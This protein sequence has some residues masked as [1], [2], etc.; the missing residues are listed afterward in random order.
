MEDWD[1]YQN[2]NWDWPEV[3]PMLPAGKAD[4]IPVEILSEIF[5]FAVQDWIPGRSRKE[6][7]LVCR[8]WHAI[9][10]SIPGIPSQLTIRRATQK[11]VVQ[12]FIQG[13]RSRL[14]V[15]VD[16]NDETDGSDFNAENLHACLLAVAQ[17]A[18]RWSSLNLISPPP[19]GE[20]TNLHILQP[21]VHLKSFKLA[22]GFGE[23]VEPLMA[24]ISKS[25]TP[26]LTTMALKDPVAVFYLV[27]PAYLHITH[28]LTALTVLLAKRMDNPADILP[29]LH[30]LEFFEARNLGLP[31]YPPDVSLPLTHTLQFLTLKSV[32]VQWMAGRVFP[33]LM[34]F[35]VK[36]PHNADIIQASQPIFMPSC[37]HL[38]YYSNNLH[39]LTHFH[40][41]SLNRLDVKSAQWNI[42]RGNPHLV[43][44]CSAVAAGAKGL[45]QLHLDVECSEQLL[46]YMLSLVP[47]LQSLWLDLA[48]PNA[49]STTFFQAFVVKKPNA[50]GVSDMVRQ[51]SQTI[52]PLC[53][54][55]TSLLLHYKRWLRNPGEKALIVALAD[56]VASR[57]SRMFSQFSL[58]L[59]FDEMLEN[60]TWSIDK[61]VKNSRSIGSTEVTLGI[62][63]PHGIVPMSKVL[64]RTGIVALPYKEAEYLR[65]WHSH[66]SSPIEFLFTHD[67]MELMVY[68]Y[69]PLPSPTS[70]PYALPLFYSLRVLV[71]EGTDPS[72]L[73]GHTFHKL[74]RCKVVGSPGSF[75]ASP[76]PSTE[77]E[78]PVCTRINIDDPYLLATF[79]LPQVHEL[80]L[81]FS[82]PKCS[83]IWQKHIAVNANLSGLT[84]LHMKKWPFDGDLISILRPLSSLETL[85][86]G[87]QRGVV[88]FSPFLPMDV[89]GTSGL[90]Q[91]SGQLQ[92][93]AILCPRMHRLQIEVEDSPLQPELVPI[94]KSIVTLR[95]E[96][97]SSLKRFTYRI[98]YKPGSHPGSQFELIGTDGSFIMENIVSVSVVEGFKLDI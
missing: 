34:Q 1:W 50:D 45:T 74:E 26:N 69:H 58:L 96:C 39:P 18:T 43:A 62:S 75:G 82:D 63:V 42:W 38:L 30:R 68:D 78:M 59:S 46:V 70:L 72:F 40:P 83:I 13:R 27:Q 56:I 64:P 32:S 36:F 24:S 89:N 84:L 97:G 79:K 25:A 8:R 81:G 41:R 93:L 49:L 21:L 65:L 22:C 16:L 47:A 87:S 71:V 55:L 88:S 51:P 33:V 61:P 86:I 90:E 37:Y 3:R 76:S 6:L 66:S 91:T 57:D 80:A 92:K 54:S 14:D 5:L 23:L 95:A 98:L 10:I 73:V 20:Y 17:A 15:R 29:H 77:T 52:T 9:M 60:S 48:R 7:M 11:E 31:F 44:L 53:P 85:I 35:Q 94:L 12:E 28:S 67:H 2:Q 19:H 4:L